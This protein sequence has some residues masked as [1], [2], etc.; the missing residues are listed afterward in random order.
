MFGVVYYVCGVILLLSICAVCNMQT[1]TYFL[2]IQFINLHVLTHI[3]DAD[4]MATAELW[5]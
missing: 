4:A 1:L 2:P 5:E 3:A